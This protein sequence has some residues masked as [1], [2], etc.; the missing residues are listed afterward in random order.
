MLTNEKEVEALPCF[1]PAAL[2][3]NARTL[4]G[5]FISKLNMAVTDHASACIGQIPSVSVLCYLR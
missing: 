3:L 2:L 5:S 1:L 4:S